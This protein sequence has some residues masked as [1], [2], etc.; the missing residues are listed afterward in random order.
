MKRINLFITETNGNL[1]NQKRLI[2]RAVKI[3]QGYAF[4]KL[5]INWD[6][7]LVVTNRVY[8]FVILEDGVGGRTYTSDFI[9]VSIDEER[10]QEGI[11]SEILVHELCHAARWGKNDERMETL[12][13]GIINE[14]IATAFEVE[15]SK[16]NS[17]QQF[18]LKTV[19]N[20]LEDENKKIFS[21]LRDNLQDRRYDYQTIFFGGNQELPRWSGYSLGY[22]IV[23]KYLD[24]TSKNIEDAFAD[25]YAKIGAVLE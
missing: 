13:D 15:F 4:S 25:E 21:V 24:Q 2:E 14:G 7:D 11:L 22:Y 8:D 23:K 5:K 3:A 6:I 9:L 10:I 17:K 19:V 16:N 12:L 18:F 20:R 1:S